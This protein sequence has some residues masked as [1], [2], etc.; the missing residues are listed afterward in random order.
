MKNR[1]KKTCFVISFLSLLIENSF[2]TKTMVAN[3]PPK[4]N[5][6][7]MVLELSPENEKNKLLNIPDKRN[8]TR[9]SSISIFL[10]KLTTY[11][12]KV[13]IL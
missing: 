13:L 9:N 1:I 10:K 7:G 8:K 11:L 6:N 12:V 2:F 5:V 4:I 3:N